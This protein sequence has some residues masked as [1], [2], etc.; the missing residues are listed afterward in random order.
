MAPRDAAPDPGGSGADANEPAGAPLALLDQ[1]RAVARVAD[2]ALIVTDPSGR[3]EVWNAGA[4]RLYGIAAADA[5]G[6]AVSTLTD[7]TDGTG[8][9]LSPQAARRVAALTGGWR[10]RL[11]AR[12]TIGPRVDG[13][14][15]LEVVITALHDTDGRAIGLLSIERDI[16]PAYRLEHEFAALGT[17]ARA[18]GGA[19]SRTEIAQAALEHLCEASRAPLG[20]IIRHDAD[21]AVVEASR[22]MDAAMLTA[23]ERLPIASSA[24]AGEVRA[25]GSVLIR[26]LNDFPMR[27]S[28]RELLGST[29]VRT[30]AAVGLHRDTAVV[31]LLMLGWRDASEPLPS[32]RSLAQAGTHVER[33]LENARLVEE[34][35]LHAQAEQALLRRLDVLDELTQLG[36]GLQTTAE[37]AQRSATLVGD[38]LGA[39]GTAYGLLSADDSRYETYQMVNVPERLAAVLIGGAPDERSAFRRFRAGEA[40]FLDTVRE[41]TEGDGIRAIA[42]GSGITAYA[43][44]PVRLGGELAGAIATFFDRPVADL[45]IDQGAL[46]AVARIASISLANFRLREQ[47][48]RSEARYRTLFEESPHAYLLTDPAGVIVQANA[49]AARLYRLSSEELSGRRLTDFTDDRGPAGDGTGHVG[50]SDAVGIRGGTGRRSDGSVFPHEVE[51]VAVRIGGESGALVLVRDLTERQRLLDELVQAQKMETV[52]ILVSGVAHELNNPIAAILGLSELIR[53]DPALPADLRESATLLL[54]EADRARRIVGTFLDFIRPR[55]PERHPTPVRPLLETIQELQ[56]YSQRSGIDWS[57]TVEP[58]LPRVS[59]D[60]SQLQQVLLNLTTNAIQA[61][62]HD[63]PAGRLQLAATAARG[64]DG[65]ETVRISVTD[66][67]PG[68]PEQDRARLF[69]PFFT[70]KEPGEGTGLGLSVSFDIVRRHEGRLSY[71]P[72]P[73]GR[74][75]IFVIELPAVRA[76]ASKVALAA[77]DQAAPP[78]PA[79]RS[80]AGEAAQPADA[81]ES[82]SQPPRQERTGRVLILDDVE[83]MRAF[84]GKALRRAG[85][86]TIVVADGATAVSEAA[87]QVIDVFLVDHR[88]AGMSG[89]DVHEALVKRDS[90][91]TRRWIFMSGDV[92]NPVLLEFAESRGIRL[93][94]KP[95]DLDTVVQAVRDVVDE[96]GLIT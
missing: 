65:S 24:L 33:A 61:M 58:N 5:L 84:L 1:L 13:E 19:R 4:E 90:P 96:M 42:P 17:L 95:F 75:A 88:M 70:T 14:I 79:W 35:L 10:G 87:T 81:V 39:V 52:G 43:A 48:E 56:S 2:D 66:D 46:D 60:R 59:V 7:S 53:R 32:A 47:L 36:L 26:D 64:S 55:A 3:V 91:L 94:A 78:Q 89:I 62:L 18:T 23:L 49:A 27:T 73:G 72:N 25:P 44:I 20:V 76:T 71:E 54:D 40:S 8:T 57:I 38:A 86:E 9:D 74:G 37:F 51:T 85:Y 41:D 77:L 21:R 16:T 83:S 30:M 92:L 28:T 45:H 12:P 67:G 50:R 29:G 80:A 93:L 31:G 11:V 68:V 82:P 34:I 15:V 69:V 6:A 22:G 63:R